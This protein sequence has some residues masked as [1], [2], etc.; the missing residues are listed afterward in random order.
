MNPQEI[1]CHPLSGDDLVPFPHRHRNE[2]VPP[3]VLFSSLLCRELVE[4]DLSQSSR[5]SYVL[6]RFYFR[7]DRSRALSSLFPLFFFLRCLFF[8]FVVGGGV[9][10]FEMISR[11][12]SNSYE[13]T[14]PS[15]SAVADVVRFSPSFW[16]FLFRSSPVLV[17][18]SYPLSF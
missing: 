15:P 8:F 4:R 14:S 3:A 12:L 13:S 7:S 10:S 6:R 2:D 16:P 18:R 11:A 17:P 9:L 1:G 5:C